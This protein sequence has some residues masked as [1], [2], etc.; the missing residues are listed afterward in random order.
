MKK[1]TKITGKKGQKNKNNTYLED[2]Q[3]RL[4]ASLKCSLDG[5]AHE[6]LM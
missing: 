1:E 4:G 5:P 2:S 6:N 3:N